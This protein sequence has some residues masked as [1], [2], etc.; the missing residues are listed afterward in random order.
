MRKTRDIPESWAA[1]SL[2]AIVF[3]LAVLLVGLLGDFLSRL[4]TSLGG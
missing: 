4:L 3:A 2:S 1:L